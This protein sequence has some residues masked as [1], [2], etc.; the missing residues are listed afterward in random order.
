MGYTE[1]YR[2]AEGELRQFTAA[3]IAGKM[4]NEDHFW[5]CIFELAAGAGLRALGL[6]V[7]YERTWDGLT[8]D[9][10]ILSPDDGPLC[11]VEVH[12]DAPPQQTHSHIRRWH[13]LAR[14]I[15]EIPV[16]VTLVLEAAGA[17]PVPPD[18]GQAKKVAAGLRKQ[19]FGLGTRDKVSSYGYTFRRLPIPTPGL[20]A[21]FEPPSA[22][23]GLVSPR[24]MMTKVNQKTSKYR[25][26]ANNRRVRRP[27]LLWIS[28]TLPFALGG[29]RPNSSARRTAPVAFNRLLNTYRV[30]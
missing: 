23:A 25:Q 11:F 17:P 9:W 29:W 10:T 2:S 3:T 4:W 16:P 8:P 20:R 12:T 21:R 22:I 18:S 1:A 6:T 14:R 30:R 15:R 27:G 19:L 28:N 13:D 24:D 5:P 7:A 26:L